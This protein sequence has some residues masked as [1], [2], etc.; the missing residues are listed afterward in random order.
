[1]Q[2]IQAIHI[3]KAPEFYDESTC[4]EELFWLQGVEES[5]TSDKKSG[6]EVE[7]RCMHEMDT[8]ASPFT[9]LFLQVF[10]FPLL[11]FNFTHPRVSGFYGSRRLALVI[12][13]QET[14]MLASPRWQRG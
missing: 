11:F 10:F 2:L 9:S 8:A 3:S 6:M 13:A 4:S 5:R 7:Y 12:S 1:M 14:V